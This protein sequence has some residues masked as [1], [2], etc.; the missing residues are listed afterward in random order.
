MAHVNPVTQLQNIT[1]KPDTEPASSSFDTVDFMK[2]M[3]AQMRNQNPLSESDNPADFMGQLAQFEMLSK[4]TAI[5]D[6][7]KV[8]Q[9][10]EELSSAASLI[11]RTVVGQQVDALPTVLDAISREMFGAPYSAVTRGQQRIIGADPRAREAASGSQAGKEIRGVVEK[12][13]VG[14]NGIP[15]LFVD[16]KVVDMFTIAV[17]E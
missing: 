5:S 12:V 9:G 1:Y 2:L 15:L 17:V 4:L 8:M 3:I 11:G 16:G 14:S 10:L 13:V 6:G 7:I